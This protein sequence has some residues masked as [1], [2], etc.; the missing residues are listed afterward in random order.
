MAEFAFDCVDIAPMPCGAGPTLV[1]RLRVAETTG[2]SVQ[3][4]ALRCQV[5]VEP[6]ARGYGEEERARLCALFG[7]TARWSRSLRAF[8]VATV[9]VMVGSF[10]GSTEA[11]LHIPVS[12][13]LE[14]AAGRYFHALRAG[15]VPLSLQFSGTAFL[16]TL[17]GPRVER[18]PWHLMAAYRLPVP[19][20][21]ELMDSYFPGQAWI[22]LRRETVDAVAH[23][24]AANSLGCWDDAILALLTAAGVATPAESGTVAA[25]MVASGSAAAGTGAP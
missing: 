22:R 21:R 15:V 13:D 16:S 11:E 3:A 9:S 20:W 8:P 7:G 2:A 5:R 17:A 4:I 25:G 10:A 24:K 6:T 19:V 12:Y 23:Y 1:A 14:V 18:V